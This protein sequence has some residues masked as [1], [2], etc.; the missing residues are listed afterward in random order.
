MRVRTQSNSRIAPC[1]GGPGSA[2]AC[3][4]PGLSSLGWRRVSAGGPATA[5][6][7]T[8]RRLLQSLFILTA[9][10]CS[11]VGQQTYPAGNPQACSRYIHRWTAVSSSVSGTNIMDTGSG[12]R[13][14]ATML[15]VGTWWD[16]ANNAIN[17]SFNSASNNGYMNISNTIPLRRAAGG[18]PPAR[19]QRPAA[20]PLA[21]KCH[22]LCGLPQARPLLTSSSCLYRRAQ[23]ADD[24]G[25]VGE[26][27]QLRERLHIICVLLRFPGHHG[28]C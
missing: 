5:G 14:D 10:A 24:R 28:Q 15:P 1:A 7:S 6:S 4:A 17:I 19:A 9:V 23:L 25:L 27:R 12:P 16:S 8:S 2:P 13:A 20:P 22:R 26:S 18:R 11:V 21:T 3:I